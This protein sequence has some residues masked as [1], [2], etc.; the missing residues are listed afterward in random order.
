[1]AV[2]KVTD[3]EALLWRLP[4]DARVARQDVTTVPDSVRSQAVG[5]YRKQHAAKMSKAGL[6]RLNYQRL[7][8]DPH[9]QEIERRLAEAYW[10]RHGLAVAGA[11]PDVE[12]MSF[13]QACEAF[14]A[15]APKV[16]STGLEEAA[17]RPLCPPGLA[18]E[19]RHPGK[20]PGRLPP[21]S[22]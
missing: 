3:W 8:D 7:H 20:L 13:I 16:G 4:A 12:A 18:Y 9:Y 19:A 22:G 15:S 10:R 21:G 14:R 1:M 11:V 6:R 2:R 5:E 17:G